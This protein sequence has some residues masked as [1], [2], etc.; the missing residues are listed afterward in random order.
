MSQENVEIVRAI[1]QAWTE[2]TSPRDLIAADME[3]VNPPYAVESGTSSD[4]RTLAKVKEVY[5]DFRIDP[6]RYIDAGDD[7]VV[8]GTAHGTG[9]SGVEVRWRQGYVWTVRDGKA[10]RFC[11]FNDPA[12]ALEA[13]GLPP[14]AA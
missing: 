10:V 2:N 14:E 1:Y 8:I 6:E 12:E 3:Y 11:W 7:V 13:I 5:P 4:R 9:A